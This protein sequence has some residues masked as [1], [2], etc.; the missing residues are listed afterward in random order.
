MA[1]PIPRA[2]MASD[3]GQV[4]HL[5]THV[6]HDG[7]VPQTLCTEPVDRQRDPRPGARLCTNCAEAFRQIQEAVERLT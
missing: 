4:V 1:G 6:R 5:A 7:W 3:R 2:T